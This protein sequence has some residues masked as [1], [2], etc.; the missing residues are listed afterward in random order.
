MK[1]FL[2]KFIGGAKNDTSG[3]LHGQEQLKRQVTAL[4][5]LLANLYG[6][7]KLVLR[8]GKLEALQLMR[9]EKLEERVLAL[10]KLVFEDP[11]YDTLPVPEDIPGILE[12]IQ[13]EIADTIARRT[14]EDQLEK[15]ISEKLQQRHEDYVKEIKMQVLK[16]NAGPENAQTLKKL[17]ILEKL[18]QRK[19]ST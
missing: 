3:K 17:A 16:E 7:D 11:T 9:S 4:Y 13:D 10:Q 19:L 8:A 2:E 12:E 14:L 18:E 1:V 5:G 6:S 15:K